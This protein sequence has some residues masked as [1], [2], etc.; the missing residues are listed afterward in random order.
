MDYYCAIVHATLETE[1][2][3]SHSRI[4]VVDTITSLW[5]SEGEDVTALEVYDLH[6]KTHDILDMAVSEWVGK[7]AHILAFLLNSV[8][9]QHHEVWAL[10]VPFLNA[11]KDI[12]VLLS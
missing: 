3:M 9:R 4:A 5:S 8:S 10:E 2:F 7:M 1:K 11:I 12:G 6:T